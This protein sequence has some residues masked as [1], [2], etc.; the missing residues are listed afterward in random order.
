MSLQSCDCKCVW[1][2]LTSFLGPLLTVPCPEGRREP[3]RKETKK[4]NQ[5]N[6]I[7]NQTKNSIQRNFIA[8][9]PTTLLYFIL[10]KASSTTY[11]NR[12][13]CVILWIQNFKWCLEKDP[14]PTFLYRPNNS[15]QELRQNHKKP[16][17]IQRVA[18]WI[19]IPYTSSVKQARH[20]YV[21]YY[22]SY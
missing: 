6:N 20:C 14:R 13:I 12:E 9:I 18:T 3:K 11:T 10:Y 5:I 1:K 17:W 8:P 21:R 22:D 16:R 15:F 4:K 2:M 7:R 19:P